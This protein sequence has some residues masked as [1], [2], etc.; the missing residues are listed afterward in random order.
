VGKGCRGG[1]RV[2]R[3]Y[4]GFVLVTNVGRSYERVYSFDLKR[5]WLVS[6]EIKLSVISI[7]ELDV[8]VS[9]ALDSY[10]RLM[11]PFRYLK[12]RDL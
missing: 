11:L 2:L 8:C 9:V 3:R 5:L 10:R 4:G 1:T 12:M 7:E 6:R